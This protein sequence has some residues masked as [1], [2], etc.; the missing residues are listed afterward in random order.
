M[1]R[2]PLDDKAIE[3]ISR[4]LLLHHRGQKNL[5]NQL[6]A[7]LKEATDDNDGESDWYRDARSLLKDV[8]RRGIEFE[9]H[10]FNQKNGHNTDSRSPFP[11]E[12]SENI[13]LEADEET[14]DPSEMSEADVAN[15]FQVEIEEPKRVKTKKLSKMTIEEIESWEVAQENS[16]DIYKVSARMKNLARAAVKANLTPQGEMV[17]NSFV[18]VVKG[19]YDFAATIADKETR[20]RLEQYARKQEEVPAN[21]ISALGAGVR[22]PE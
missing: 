6:L 15:L 17:T 18:H 13:Q 14:G 11:A 10:R 8:S 22:V 3:E 5:V 2:Y 4:D 20:V 7:L 21:L 16:N 12:P 9:N 19:L 1:A